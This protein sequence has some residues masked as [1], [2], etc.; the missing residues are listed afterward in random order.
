MG[1]EAQCTVSLN[2]TQ[3]EARALLETSELIVRGDGRVRVPFAEMR[4]VSANDGTLTIEFGGGVLALELGRQAQRWADKI[5]NPPSRLD[6]LGVKAGH[7]VAVIG[8][9]DDGFADELRARGADVH[10]DDE[11]AS[12]SDLIFLGAERRDAL[13][14]L[15]RLQ[16]S[17]R[18]NGA[19]WI[20]RP[21]GSAEISEGD[22]M[23]AA[24]AAGLVD[25]KVARFSE[26]HTAE[27]LVIPVTRR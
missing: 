23:N 1:A 17:L 16:A 9:R 24:K 19:I 13:D 10:E 21:R 20:V 27:K 18:R 6:K 15:D 2:G 25:T 26:T 5:A 3:Y 7:R 14:R 11:P 8:V 22:V 4:S 12:E